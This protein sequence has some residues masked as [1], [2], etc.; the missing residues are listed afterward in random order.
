MR[1]AVSFAG[2]SL[3]VLACAVPAEFPPESVV[4][5]ASAGFERV[6]A[7][8]V[9]NDRASTGGVSWVDF[10]G[11][12]DDDLFVTNGYDVSA[13]DPVGQQNLLYENQGG[14][15]LVP[16]PDSILAEAGEFSSGSTW[17][18]YDRDGD[19]DVF[20]TNQQGQN[21]A[22]YRN[23]GDGV[24][25]RLDDAA[26]AGDGG[27]SYAASWIDVD[28]DGDLD[29]FVANGGLSHDEGNFFYRNEGEGMFT[30]LTDGA[31]VADQ[32]GTCGFAWGDYDD[33]GFPDLYITD[34]SAGGFLYHND[35]GLVFTRMDVS[36]FNEDK[37]PTAAADWIDFDN[38]GDLDLYVATLYGL[39]NFL[40]RQE[41]GGVFVR[42]D[43]VPAAI[44][45]GYSHG[46]AWADWDN[47]GDLDL[48][49]VNWGA[50][51]VPY[52]NDDGNL[53]RADGGDLGRA[54]GYGACAA[55]ADL[56]GDGGLDLYVGH[57]PNE[58]GKGEQNPLFRNRG[59][60]GHWLGIRLRGVRSD[61]FGIGARVTVTVERDGAPRT[62]LR[63]VTAHAGWRSQNSLVQHFGLG[64]LAQAA[65]IVVRWP[66]GTVDRLVNVDADRIIEI[67]EGQAVGA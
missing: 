37:A 15:N 47:D 33:D 29:L 53:V 51:H 67:V 3:M 64:D 20:V 55:W 7:G 35:G 11:D 38:D 8:A 5:D 6:S 23:D 40:Y 22:L 25:V 46:A 65:Q 36:P 19:L 12:G 42:V 16:L 28:L 14:G 26:P 60:R 30:R 31:L 57:W 56:D 49:V 9:V 24:F 54:I 2:L 59:R 52:R 10:D 18:D 48:V 63:E 39:A 61:T 45:S 34:R 58:P 66:S 17:G 4:D 13:A 32:R 43:D 21:N 41:A 44:D 62:Q 27:Q 50:A 1:K